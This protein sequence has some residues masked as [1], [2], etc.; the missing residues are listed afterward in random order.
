MFVRQDYSRSSQLVIF[1][2]CPEHLR[3][4]FTGMSASVGHIH[5][6]GWYT[7]FVKEVGK[8]F[9]QAIWEIRGIVWDI[10]AY[11]KEIE[12]FRP[13]FLFLHDIARH[14]SHSKEILDVALDTVDSLIYEN[15]MLNQANPSPYTKRPWDYDDSKRQLYFGRKSIF[16]T[17]L[18]CM[19]LSERLQNE[20]NLAFNIV[21]QRN[22]EVSL[23]LAKHSLS[24]NTM[25]K[26]VAIVSMIYLPGT[27][28]SGIFGMS[29]FD[30]NSDKKKL[31]VGTDFWLYW[32]VT[33]AL[34]L[35][36]MGMLK[37]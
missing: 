9:D 20:I 26:T 32:I 17:K 29:F 2:D 37:S 27:F 6:F 13:E 14:V 22:N 8:L 28:V 1:L 36:T 19:S 34:T 33:I 12:T 30:Y 4:Q 16:A 7:F 35:A 18:R 10:E 3:D 25:M 5:P 23:Q 21:S 24:D 15:E 11:H 31:D